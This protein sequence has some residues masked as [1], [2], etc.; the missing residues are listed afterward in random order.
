MSV[1]AN[2]QLPPHSAPPAVGWRLVVAL[3]ALLWERVWPNLWPALAVALIYVSLSLFDIWAFTPGWLHLSLLIVFAL[4]VLGA[5]GFGLLRIALPLRDHARRR[6]EQESGLNHRPLS[7]IEDRLATGTGDAASAALWEEH[8]RRTRQSLRNLHVGW[9]RA[10]LARSADPWGLRIII[11][12]L[13]VVAFAAAREDAP[14]RMALAFQPDFASLGGAGGVTIDAWIAPPDYTGQPPIF[15]QRAA[16]GEPQII[17]VPIGSV[18][19][20]RVHGGR[21]LPQL[22]LDEAVTPFTVVDKSNFEVEHPLTAGATIRFEQRE[23]AIAE[24]SIAIVPDRNPVIRFNEEPV[25]T[26]RQALRLDFSADDDY[27]VAAAQAHIRRAD[28]DETMALDLPLP[29]RDR[30]EVSET[31]FHDLTPHPWAGLPVIM[32]L[33]AIDLAEQKGISS[34]VELIL[35][36]REF[37]HPVAREI[38][39]QRR[40][41]ALAPDRRDQ[42]AESLNRLSARPGTYYEDVTAFLALRSSVW[43]LRRTASSDEGDAEISGLL[44]Q[45]ALRIEDGTLSLAEQE[46]RAAQDRLMEALADPNA[47]DQEINQRIQ[48]VRDALEKFLQALAERALQNQQ[49]GDN[50]EIPPGELLEQ[51][52]LQQLLDQ[53]Q[54]LSETGARD[55]A[56]DLL[57][58]LR[59]LLE[60]LRDGRVANMPDGNSPGEEML[61]DLNELL[62]RQQELLDETYQE[63]QRGER[64]EQ[65]PGQQGQQGQGDQPSLAERQEELRRR[66]GEM[67]RR[68]GDQGQDIPGA[69]GRAER[70]MDSARGQLEARRPGGAIDPM[71]EALDQLRQGA[72]SVIRDML[73]ALGSDPGLDEGPNPFAR[74][75]RDP[76]GRPQNGFG[77][78][79]DSRVEIPSEFD[80]QRAREILQELYRR[81]GD[82]RRPQIELD[83]LN[84]LLRRF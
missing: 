61:R 83:Y 78:L 26:V 74:A 63:S 76:F 18:L 37:Q 27:G 79:D 65:R 38:V 84:R 51:D 80:V 58:Q 81:S 4:A 55:A 17:D 32:H 12:L 77:I 13:V 62:R 1:E 30:T 44:W 24:W 15:L 56:R 59:E 71:T 36:E 8:H 52:Q 39:E 69:L 43:Q 47:T 20:A 14:R 19:F 11:A 34:E 7:A 35:P 3:G 21:G 64:G 29:Q 10:G 5:L 25:A 46:L 54:R 73:E 6:L 57:S 75:G 31:S 49:A 2:K 23:Q 45:T 60:S 66:L 9:P 28:S 40:V 67:M 68:L 42:V 48:E 33:E 16:D 70:S 41:L 72:N 53:A 22:R 82:R 50:R